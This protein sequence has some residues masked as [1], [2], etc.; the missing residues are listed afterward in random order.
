MIFLNNNKNK[1]FTSIYNISS[2]NLSRYHITSGPYFLRGVYLRKLNPQC[3]ECNDHTSIYNIKT[4][5]TT[6]LVF[7]S[8]HR[9]Y[10]I[11][12]CTEASTQPESESIC[13]TTDANK[14][15]VLHISR[16]TTPLLICMLPILMH[17]VLLCFIWL[18]FYHKCPVIS[19][20]MYL[21]IPCI[22]DAMIQFRYTTI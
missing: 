9:K 7:L 20:A 1:S 8:R 13:F 12:S 16:E 15:R 14:S 17:M 18:W 3:P 4:I 21:Y 10:Q 19:C 5:V 22:A 11:V 2:I 6:D